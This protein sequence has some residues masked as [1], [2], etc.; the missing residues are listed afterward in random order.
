MGLQATNI[1][2]QQAVLRECYV[3]APSWIKKQALLFIMLT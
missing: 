3:E 2:M 1:F